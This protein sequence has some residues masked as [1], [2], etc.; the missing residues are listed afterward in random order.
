M[1]FTPILQSHRK[2][3]GMPRALVGG[4][5]YLGLFLKALASVAY[6]TE[7]LLLSLLNIPGRLPLR[8]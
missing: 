6:R 8:D 7:M 1:H 2:V 3:Y 5:C 4:L